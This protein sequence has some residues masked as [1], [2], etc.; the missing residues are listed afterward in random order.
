MLVGTSGTAFRHGPLQAVHEIVGGERLREEAHAGG[1]GGL[2]RF[3]QTRVTGHEHEPGAVQ[4]LIAIGDQFQAAAI[5]Q[6]QVHHHQVV[7]AVVERMTSLP[8][9]AGHLHL[10]ARHFE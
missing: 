8:V 1:T 9:G 7:A 4:A 10:S 2:R 3:R 6:H 5:R